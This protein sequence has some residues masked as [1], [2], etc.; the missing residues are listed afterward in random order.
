MTIVIPL[1]ELFDYGNSLIGQRGGDYR[2]WCGYPQ[3]SPGL[4]TDHW[5]GAANRDREPRMRNT[6]M[7]DDELREAPD[8]ESLI[9]EKFWSY[10]P[11]LRDSR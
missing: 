1:L 2:S 11:G 5:P 10:L 6:E 7:R 8:A 9:S 4:F 3:S